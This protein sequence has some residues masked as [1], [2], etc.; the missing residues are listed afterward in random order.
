MNPL[1]LYFA[2]GESLYPG[3][4]L[5]L[6]TLC[7][8]PW[9][10]GKWQH[11]LRN[12][13]A[14]IALAL[15]LLASA[16][17]P[18]IFYIALIITCALRFILWDFLA[19]KKSRKERPFRIA[20]SLSLAICILIFVAS[21]LNHRTIPQLPP[22]SHTRLTIIG[23]S[24][25]AGIDAA[26]PWPKR[27]QQTTGIPV[28]NLSLPGIGVSE[29]LP[30]ASKVSP[31]DTLI[32]LEIGGNDILANLPTEDFER[33]LSK[34]L[35]TLEK[36][37]RTLIMFELP[38]LPHKI[39]FGRVQRQLAEKYHVT[40]IP[41][42]LLI[43]I[44]S[45]NDATSDGLHLSPSGAQNMAAVIEKILSPILTPPQ[46]PSTETLAHERPLTPPKNS[47]N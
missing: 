43:Q 31:D 18:W 2:S 20:V 45:A 6:M 13:L 8:A 10:R 3:A 47:A 4:I 24:I 9:L 16:P 19:P 36:P 7:V 28:K 29:A 39:S 15:M 44:L 21:E 17:L 38:L 14:F 27:F 12:F 22:Q 25:S 35:T 1:A 34:L 23:D 32:L 33:D 26:N 42:R 41:K 5:L 37:N 40:L 11:R 46:T 30:L